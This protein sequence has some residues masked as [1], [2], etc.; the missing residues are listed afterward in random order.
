[1][2]RN[3]AANFRIISPPL[4]MN[5]GHS[6]VES[7]LRAEVMARPG[8]A[9]VSKCRTPAVPLWPGSPRPPRCADLKAAGR[10]AA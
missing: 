3:S 8:K 5:S 6:R 10:A 1:V 4:W 7:Y 2:P 9:D